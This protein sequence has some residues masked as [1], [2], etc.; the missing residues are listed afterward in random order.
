LL[1]KYLNYAGIYCYVFLA[2]DNLKTIKEDFFMANND[3]I[4]SNC[5]RSGSDIPGTL[6]RNGTQ[7]KIAKCSLNRSDR[8]TIAFSL[9]A[10]L[11][12]YLAG[13]TSVGRAKINGVDYI[14]TESLSG[15]VPGRK[16]VVIYEPVNKTLNAGV[17][18]NGSSISH[19]H[20]LVKNSYVHWSIFSPRIA[21]ILLDNPQGE[22][23]DSFKAVKD[24]FSQKGVLGRSNDMF[25]LNDYLY[26]TRDGYIKTNKEVQDLYLTGADIEE[27]LT[28]K[29]IG[30]KGH[31]EYAISS[32]QNKAKKRSSK[33]SSGTS[34][35][36]TA[37]NLEWAT[38]LSPEDEALIPNYDLNRIK[39][40]PDIV[41]VASI[42]HGEHKSLNPVTNILM[43]GEAG[44]GK[45]TKARLLAQLLGVPYEFENLSFNSEESDIVG[46]Y[47]P[48][49]DGTFEFRDTAFIRRY[50]DGGVF[51]AMELS[52]ARPGVLGKINSALDSTGILITANGEKIK[53]HP[54]FIFVATTNVDYAGCQLINASLKSRFHMLMEVNKLPNKELVDVVA[55]ESGNGDKGLIAKMVDAVNKIAIKIQEE[56]ISNGVC[57]TREL[58]NWARA[59]K[60]TNDPIESAKTTIL[61]CVSFEREV[62]EEIID[63]ILRPMF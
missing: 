36:A 4:W 21:E 54:N 42:I 48:K 50:R 61:P 58:I 15:N 37:Y 11:I 55:T 12:S 63:T 38:P 24:E 56:Q 10:S 51:E 41:N 47:V 3:N 44:G 9:T 28:P 34:N 5:F 43:Y 62:Q 60:Y 16:Y 6:L 14:W 13:R 2:I 33:Q 19:S 30:Q 22:F 59:V 27:D 7:S 49:E 1:Q 46:S 35:L 52:F 25:V 20:T 26:Q 45:T 39:P 18:E 17:F 57:S 40:T 8:A 23:A 31:F 29:I 53:R 32:P